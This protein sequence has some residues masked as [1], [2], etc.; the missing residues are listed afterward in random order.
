MFNLILLFILSCVAAKPAPKKSVEVITNSVTTEIIA[1]ECS[2][3][4]DN[5]ACDFK[6]MSSTGNEVSLF[7]FRGK[8]VILQFSVMWCHWCQVGAKDG[9]AVVQHYGDDKVVWLSVFL[10]NPRG[11]IPSVNDLKMW[12]EFYDIED[13]YLLVGNEELVVEQLGKGQPIIKGFPSYFIID[14]H[15][16]INGKFLGYNPDMLKSAIKNQIQKT[17]K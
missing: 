11:K 14:E 13:Q 2:Y 9:D 3:E 12:G 4:T 16:V 8:T 5:V 1:E 6:I 17:R 15:G 7:Q 10:S